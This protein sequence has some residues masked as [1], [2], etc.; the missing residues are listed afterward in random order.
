MIKICY[1]KTLSG[2]ENRVS[3]QDGKRHI[4]VGQGHLLDKRN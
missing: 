4:T 2:Q 3:C 1:E